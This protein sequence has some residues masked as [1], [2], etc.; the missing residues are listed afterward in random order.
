MIRIFVLKP[1]K[2]QQQLQDLGLN[3]KGTNGDRIKRLCIASLLKNLSVDFDV[4]N[5]ETVKQLVKEWPNLNTSFKIYEIFLN[6]ASS[7]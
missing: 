2:I 6:S 3:I 5:I 1:E 4:A 7:N